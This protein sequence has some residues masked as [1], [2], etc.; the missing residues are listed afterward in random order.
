L[1]KPASRW[2]AIALMAAAVLGFP[3]VAL[4]EY[5]YIYK[6]P[7]VPSFINT[8]TNN[9]LFLLTCV[10]LGNNRLRALIAVSFIFSIIFTA[11][12]ILPLYQIDKRKIDR[13][14]TRK[15]KF[16]AIRGCKSR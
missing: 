3:L 8:V 4:Y 10:L 14:Y 6:Q 7:V 11:F 1:N 5:L 13:W 15:G 16:T 2:R 9:A 12:F